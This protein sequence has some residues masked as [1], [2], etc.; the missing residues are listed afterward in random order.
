MESMA[1]FYS[2]GSSSPFA[3]HYSEKCE[4]LN[5]KDDTNQ[6]PNDLVPRQK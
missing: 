4:D 1:N 6:P 2:M 5:I 3:H